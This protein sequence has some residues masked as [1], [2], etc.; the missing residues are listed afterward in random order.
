MKRKIRFYLVLCVIGLCLAVTALALRRFSISD[1]VGGMMMGGGSGLC[2]MA[3]A[4]LLTLYSEWKH[5]EE[6]RKKEIAVKDE[7]NT[8]IQRRAKAV[9]GD[10]LQWGVMV[11]AWVSIGLDAPLWVTLLAVSIFVLRSVL[12]VFLIG[13]YQKVM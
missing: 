9:S 13:Y 6:A 11:V 1:I 8:A 4:Q 2:A 5:P 10:I 3:L 12:D 7:R